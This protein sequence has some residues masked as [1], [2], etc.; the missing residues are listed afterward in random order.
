MEIHKIQAQH[1]AKIYGKRKVVNDLSM[2]MQQ[3]EV[4]GIL[5]PNGAGKT[6]TFYMILGLTKPNEGKVLLDNK[7]ITHLPMYRRARLGLGYLAQT[8]SIFSKLT[9]EENILA[10]LQTLKISKQE[11]KR[12]LEEALAELN[13]TPLAKQ[14]AYTLSGG[15]RRKLEITRS[16]LTN[17]TF[18]FM[19]E[20]FAG[21]DPI[22]VA[23]IQDIIAKLRD[24]NIGIM[25]T[26]HNV[27]E[28]LK[29]VN[30]AYIIF[31]GKI[32][33]S[34]SSWELINDEKAKKLYLGDRFLTNPFESR[35]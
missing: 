31:E 7:D 22:T 21:V 3:G 18:I 9:V 17:P 15:E 6:T 16:L 19:D 20:P 27:F 5:G 28:T 34:G 26:D 30:R 11:Q 8:P 1:L 35:Q 13:L 32:I 10:I 4:V 14:K 33:V 29:I 24:K 23:D 12:K 25:V 2:E